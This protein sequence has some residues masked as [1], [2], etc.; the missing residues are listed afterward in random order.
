MQIF[1]PSI[2]QK[3]ASNFYHNISRESISPLI[4]KSTRIRDKD[5]KK[6][7][8]S[9]R[10]DMDINWRKKNVQR[11]SNTWCI[12]VPQASNSVVQRQVD[13][14]QL[15]GCTYCLERN[16]ESK[17]SW[18]TQLPFPLYGSKSIGCRLVRM[19]LAKSNTII[20]IIIVVVV[21]L[22]VGFVW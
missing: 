19:R 1:Y 7:I 15:R 21:P 6:T 9:P 13:E 20:I 16:V 8:T 5:Q 2:D 3:I 17:V 4:S 22:S 12:Q 18:V 14:H 11:S 10:L